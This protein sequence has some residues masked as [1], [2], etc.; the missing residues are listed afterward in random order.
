MPPSADLRTALA[1]ALK[2]HRGPGYFPGTNDVTF[3]VGAGRDAAVEFADAILADPAVRAAL[4]SEVE[5]GLRAAARV[6]EDK[7]IVWE[8][9]NGNPIEPLTADELNR[10]RSDPV[11]APSWRWLVERL[12]ATLDIAFAAA[13]PPATPELDAPTPRAGEPPEPYDVER[14]LMKC[15]WC[16]DWLILSDIE[17]HLAAEGRMVPEVA[18]ASAE[19]PRT[20][21][22]E[23]LAMKAE[24]YIEAVVSYLDESNQ[25]T[26]SRRR[27]VDRTGEELAEL[28]V[29]ALAEPRGS[30][31][32]DSRLAELRTALERAAAVMEANAELVHDISIYGELTVAAE[33]AREAAS[34][35]SPSKQ[36]SVSEPVTEGRHRWGPNGMEPD[37][38]GL[39]L[40]LANHPD[41]IVDPVEGG[42]EGAGLRE[43]REAL[44]NYVNPDRD[45]DY[46][47]GALI[48]DYEHAIL[49]EQPE[50]TGPQVPAESL[51]ATEADIME[52]LS[53]DNP[54]ARRHREQ[55][56]YGDSMGYSSWGCI[57]IVDVVESGARKALIAASA[58][59]EI[60]A[61]A[62]P[63]LERN[64]ETCRLD[65][66][67]YCQE[68]SLGVADAQGLCDQ[69]R[70]QQA[71]ARI[72]ETT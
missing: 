60:M 42:A 16:G 69:G 18:E 6:T 39:W 71:A 63:Y 33:E 20:L 12:F 64:E 40:K 62:L 51:T 47:L 23:R 3:I 25:F 19:P 70:A 34:R 66:H 21:D 10:Y 49:R 31:A 15:G 46:K 24:E 1:E 2:N 5:P 61:W 45:D 11:A 48:Y 68:H 17:G 65:H 44:L 41:P 27:H 67:G 57:P 8:D 13:V 7:D 54:R 38:N 50:G 30:P 26:Y 59:A 35:P 9:S 32:P 55:V 56:M 28:V 36:D 43:A 4:A 37:P 72:R 29:A 53:A 22:V 14:N 52:R 58:G